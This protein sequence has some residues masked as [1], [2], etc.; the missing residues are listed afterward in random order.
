[1]RCSRSY[2]RFH[3]ARYTPVPMKLGSY[4]IPAGTTFFLLTHGLHNGKRIWE[5]P[6][7]FLPDRWR[8]RDTDLWC[9][10]DSQKC[11][12]AER[13]V[14]GREK[15]NESNGPYIDGLDNAE[16]SLSG[17]DKRRI[18]RYLPFSS[19]IRSCIGQN[20]AQMNMLATLAT[21]FSRFEFKI[22][23]ELNSD[24]AQYEL[25]ITRI[26]TFPDWHGQGLPV[27]CRPR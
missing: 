6:N 22:S 23:D 25:Q 7:E 3:A 9:P 21:V 2:Y 15:S 24:A 16:P 20:L 5:K 14:T 26:T 12:P 1:M 4:D 13:S 19:G 27:L 10:S 18:R 8:G 17:D 11:I